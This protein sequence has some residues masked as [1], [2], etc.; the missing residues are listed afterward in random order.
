MENQLKIQPSQSSGSTSEATIRV[1]TVLIESPKE[2]G[3]ADK[4]PMGG[5]L[6]LD[7]LFKSALP[8]V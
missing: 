3:R 2:K 4:D 1:H 5:E 6:F 8:T 7:E